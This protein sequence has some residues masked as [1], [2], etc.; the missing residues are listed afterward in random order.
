MA[1]KPKE[2]KDYPKM[3]IDDFLTLSFVEDVNY[4]TLE[5]G[6]MFRI[7][8]TAY[9]G[10]LSSVY[11]ILD[12]VKENRPGIFEETTNIKELHYRK[13]VFGIEKS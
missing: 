13:D 2:Y 11:I 3:S 5:K 6:K 7:A 10:Q 4:R 8:K 1:T 12:V 9:P